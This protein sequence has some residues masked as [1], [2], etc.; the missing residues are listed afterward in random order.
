[1]AGG[2]GKVPTPKIRA[3]RSA[4]SPLDLKLLL[5]ISPVGYGLNVT[6]EVK[7]PLERLK[8]VPLVQRSKCERPRPKR[9][10]DLRLF[11]EHLRHPSTRL[12]ANWWGTSYRRWVRHRWT[13][14]LRKPHLPLAKCFRRSEKMPRAHLSPVPRPYRL[15]MRLRCLRS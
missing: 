7:H 1:M 14:H 6:R 11:L 13:S 5:E 3:K 8:P 4:D 10:R 9:R 12:E 15:A 2:G